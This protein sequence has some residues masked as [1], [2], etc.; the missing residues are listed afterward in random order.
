MGILVPESWTIYVT[1]ILE[2]IFKGTAE[3][4]IASNGLKILIDSKYSKYFK[5]S[6]EKLLG[7]AH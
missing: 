1:E 7:G 3:C 5:F 6:K 2:T 4:K